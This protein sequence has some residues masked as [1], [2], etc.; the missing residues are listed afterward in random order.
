MEEDKPNTVTTTVQPMTGTALIMTHDTLHAGQVITACHKYI[1]RS[2]LMFHRLGGGMP[3]DQ[4]AELPD[5]QLAEKLYS[6]SIIKQRNGDPVGS[7]ADYVKALTI[8]AKL[9]SS[10]S[11]SAINNDDT[12]L[13]TLGEDCLMLCFRFLGIHGIVNASSVSRSWKTVCGSGILWRELFAFRWPTL[14][15]AEATVTDNSS[16]VATAAITEDFPNFKTTNLSVLEQRRIGQQHNS[17]C[18]LPY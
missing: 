4:L 13:N 14:S 16:S 9:P 15:C 12:L 1:A 8:Q 7:T 5:R 2:D 11:P 6:S 18:T 10:I 17:V 3:K